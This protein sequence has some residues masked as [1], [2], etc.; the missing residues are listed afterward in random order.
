MVEAEGLSKRYGETQ[1][2]DDVDLE[3]AT[4]SILGVLGPN[5]AGKTTALRIL[6]TLSTPDTRAGRGSPGT[7]WSPRPPPCGARSAS[8][9][10]TR[11]STSC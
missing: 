10:R 7:T 2:L 6:T 1:A 8:P 5:G 11:R 4:G 9:A 3:V